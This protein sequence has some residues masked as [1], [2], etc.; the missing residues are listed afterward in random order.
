M[1]LVAVQCNHC[2]A[3]LRI[4]ETTSFVTC[5]HCG[6]QLAVQRTETA[7]FTE[8]INAID[9][10]TTQIAA[11]LEVMRLQNRI[12][13][14]DREWESKRAAVMIGVSQGKNGE[15][16]RSRATLW[17][18][19]FVTTGIVLVVAALATEGFR[20]FA[21][22]GLFAIIA[23]VLTRRWDSAMADKFQSLQARYDMERRRLVHQLRAAEKQGQG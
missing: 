16:S 8:A 20:M 1:I 23:G 17:R 21:F 4:S 13:I 3:S 6:S 2:G 5:A 7:T 10:K 12:E 22:F 15:P 14:L 19:L 9:Q 18:I 11:N